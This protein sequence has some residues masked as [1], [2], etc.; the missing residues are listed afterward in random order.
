MQVAYKI[1]PEESRFVLVPC[2][3]AMKTSE[4]VS[5]AKNGSSMSKGMVAQ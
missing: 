1:N 4:P 5:M 3:L 2:D